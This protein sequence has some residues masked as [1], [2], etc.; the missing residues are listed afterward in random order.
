MKRNDRNIF[1]NL[2]LNKTNFTINW[3]ILKNFISYT[4][5]KKDEI[6]V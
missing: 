4:E 3:S 5:G 2:K 1:R 6:Y